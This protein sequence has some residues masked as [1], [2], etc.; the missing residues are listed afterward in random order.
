MNISHISVVTFWQLGATKLGTDMIVYKKKFKE[1]NPNLFLRIWS[2]LKE[3]LYAG[4]IY[5]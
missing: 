1:V 2:F 5:T 4:E 3:I